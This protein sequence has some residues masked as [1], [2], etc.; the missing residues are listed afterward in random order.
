MGGST[1]SLQGSLEA[2]P[3]PDVLG[4]LAVSK[5]SGELRVQGQPGEGRVWMRAGAVANAEAAGARTLVDAVFELL[6]IERGTFTFDPGAPVPE[7]KESPLEPLLAEARAELAAKTERLADQEVEAEPAA[8]AGPTLD[9]LVSIP[10]NLRRR[11]RPTPEPLPVRRSKLSEAAAR[12]REVERRQETDAEQSV[13]DLLPAAAAALSPENATALVR[14]LAELGGDEA[15]VVEAV[16]A[17]SRA[18]T[19]EE[20]VAALE[21]V[22]RKDQGEPLNRTLLMKFLSSVRS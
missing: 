20:R 7:G 16:E 13:E 11:P 19:T 21:G 15:E 10:A 1:V 18:D 22:L 4:L 8:A 14:E 2:F 12:R 5:K 3:L 17:A 6:R 9:E